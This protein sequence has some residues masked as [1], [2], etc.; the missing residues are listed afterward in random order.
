MSKRIYA[1]AEIMRADPFLDG[2]SDMLQAKLSLV[3]S[4][5]RDFTFVPSLGFGSLCID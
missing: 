3:V 1:R 4:P 2:S 5:I